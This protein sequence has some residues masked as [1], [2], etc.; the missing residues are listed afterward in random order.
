MKR[1]VKQKHLFGIEVMVVLPERLH[2]I[3]C[4]AVRYG[5]VKQVAALA[6]FVKIKAGGLKY[7]ARHL[8]SDIVPY[9]LRFRVLLCC[10]SPLSAQPTRAY[11]K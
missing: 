5:W 3:G 4:L 1:E 9:V 11:R 6:V 10:G 8:E 7:K 2:A